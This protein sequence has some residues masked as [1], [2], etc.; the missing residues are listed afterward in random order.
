MQWGRFPLDLMDEQYWWHRVRPIESTCVS[1]LS[2]LP[3]MLIYF[4]SAVYIEVQFMTPEVTF[5]RALV[6]ASAFMECRWHVL[7]G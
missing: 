5:P 1:T 4:P 3:I 6:L 7:L 2:L